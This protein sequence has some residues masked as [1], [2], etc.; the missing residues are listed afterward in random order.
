MTAWVN[1]VTQT[2]GKKA[3]CKGMPQA[4][5]VLMNVVFHNKLFR[6]T[7]SLVFKCI[8]LCNREVIVGY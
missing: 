8:Y 5:E 7:F 1:G 4:E 3:K 2:E 6:T